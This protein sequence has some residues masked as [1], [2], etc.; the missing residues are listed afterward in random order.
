MKKILFVIIALLLSIGA[1]CQEEKKVI[2]PNYAIVGGEMDYVLFPQDENGNVSFVDTIKCNLTKEQIAN[3]LT[4]LLYDFEH[5]E[6]IDIDD[7]LSIDGVL[8]FNVELGAGEAYVD[9]PYVGLVLRNGS[10]VEYSVTITYDNNVLIY[11][12]YN[13]ETHR[14]RIHG[15]AKETGKPNIIHWQRVNALRRES[16]EYE[17]RKSKRAKENYK[18]KIDQIEIEKNQYQAEYDAVMGFIHSIANVVIE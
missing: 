8:R 10:E 11:K 14:R 3:K 17:G 2:Y 12:L 13:F 18:E 16:L 4:E 7:L 6:K 15:E 5:F 1:Y 9:V